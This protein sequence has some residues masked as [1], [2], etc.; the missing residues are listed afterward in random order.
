[1]LGRRPWILT[2]ASRYDRAAIRL[3]TIVYFPPDVLRQL[4]E[5]SDRRKISRSSIV[6]AA[7]TSFLSPDAADRTEAALSRRLDRL[8]R[9]M[10]RLERD[11]AIG[12]EALGLF[13]RLWMTAT[14]SLPTEMNGGADAKGRGRFQAFVAALADRLNKG[15]SF[16]TDI[17]VDSVRGVPTASGGGESDGQGSGR[18]AAETVK[19]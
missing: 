10:Q 4:I 3:R 2:T 5:L 16:L 1:M 17:P 9:Q 19:F 6:E 14:P 12:T 15:A 8:S 11:T 7:V 13:I 18:T